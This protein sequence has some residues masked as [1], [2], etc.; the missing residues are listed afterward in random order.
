MEEWIG[1]GGGFGEVVCNGTHKLAIIYQLSIMG[2]WVQISTR[3]IINL[4]IFTSY[5][6]INND[7]I[8]KAIRYLGL[9][10]NVDILE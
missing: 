2:L 9:W 7:K 1:G 8:F 10:K 4:L 3:T 5:L 6:N